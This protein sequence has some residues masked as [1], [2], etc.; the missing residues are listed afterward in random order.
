[1]TYDINRL[2]GDAWIKIDN[3][4]Y[5][6]NANDWVNFELKNKFYSNL[7]LHART[8]LKMKEK[9]DAEFLSIECN[10]C[11]SLVNE[12]VACNCKDDPLT[13][14]LTSIKS[15]KDIHDLVDCINKVN[16]VG[17]NNA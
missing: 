10:D 14:Y 12:K 16:K 3:T 1:M 2:K 5:V 15:G 13:E 9:N 4:F 6:K 8:T 7:I 11:K 17:D